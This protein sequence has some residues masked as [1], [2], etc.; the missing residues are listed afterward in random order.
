MQF[1]E[2]LAC[3]LHPAL[4]ILRGKEEQEYFLLPQMPPHLHTSPFTLQ[5]GELP[6]ILQKVWQR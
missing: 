3:R 6:K 2:E 5:M 1:E 4:S